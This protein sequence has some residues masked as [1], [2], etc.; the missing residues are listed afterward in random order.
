M[1][2]PAPVLAIIQGK[3]LIRNFYGDLVEIDE[4]SHDIARKLAEEAGIDLTARRQGRQSLAVFPVPRRAGES[5]HE[6][7][8]SAGSAPCCRSLLRHG[9]VSIRA[10][11]TGMQ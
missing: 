5:G 6:D 4:R 11:G 1:T 8:R 10:S 2:S 9:A 3:Q 7:R